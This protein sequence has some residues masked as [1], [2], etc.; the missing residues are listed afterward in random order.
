MIL[1]LELL[2]SLKYATADLNTLDRLELAAYFVPE[3]EEVGYVATNLGLAIKEL[4]ELIVQK[5]AV[6]REGRT[7]GNYYLLVEFKYVSC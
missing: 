1:H 2:K 4:L 3:I 5:T 6:T 7:N